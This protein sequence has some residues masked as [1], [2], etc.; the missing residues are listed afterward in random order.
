[1]PLQPGSKKRIVGTEHLDHSPRPAD[2]LANVTGKALGSEA[3]RLRDIDVRGIPPA[4]LH[5]QR[6]MGVFR[7]GFGCDSPNLLKRRASQHSA[8][9]TEEGCIPK[10]VTVLNDAVEQLALIRN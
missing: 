10:I 9:S 1:M 4:H 5:T 3:G 6:G 2:S 8:G 7:Y